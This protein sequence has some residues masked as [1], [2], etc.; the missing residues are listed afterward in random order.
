M[1]LQTLQQLILDAAV[2]GLPPTAGTMPLG[3][4]GRQQW[5]L[6]KGDLPLPAAVVKRAAVTHNSAW[7]RRFLGLTQSKIAP[8]G[9][10][11]MCPQ[12]FERQLA[13]GA[14]GIT[15]ATVGQMLICRRYGIGRI[16]LA[17][18]LIGRLEI[19]AV[20]DE[21]RRDPGLDF[22]CLIDSLEGVRL[23]ADAAAARLV[24]RPVQL[25]LEGG[26][27]GGRTGC[28]TVETALQVARA[29]K[30]AG[31]HLALR[32][33]EG[34]EGLIGGAAAEQD[35]KVAAFIDSLVEIARAC[36]AEDLFAAG[37]IILSA[38]GSAFFDLAASRLHNRI[39]DRPIEVVLR[40]GCYLTHDSKS[41][42]DLVERLME[43][44]PAAK[45]LGEGLQPALE[46]WAYVQSRPEPTRAIATMGKRDVGFDITLPLL[47][48][49]YRPGSHQAPQPVADG[50]KVAVLNDQ[51]AH[52]EIPA[53]SPL[54]VGDMLAFG[55]SHPCT[56][57]DRWQLLYEVDEAYNVVGGLRT[58]F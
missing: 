46:V 55:V 43:R 14:W 25:L 18:Q 32:G 49:W 56:T 26:I 39:G 35:A 28:R 23:L 37:P 51:H 10:T 53:S 1:N 42:R 45:S 48:Q 27:A 6:L 36:A 4:V 57:F 15:V 11:T 50:S 47:E 58:F 9:K 34:F 29:V 13:D 20:L 12:L 7:M 38:G 41:Y 33:V 5:N 17:N 44:M 24:G 52:I 3:Q 40:S 8:H 2:K 30:A 16:V 22:Y 19:E 21:L 31:P 54:K